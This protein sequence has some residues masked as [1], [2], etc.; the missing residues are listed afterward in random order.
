M[1]ELDS[2]FLFR[3]LYEADLKVEY[4][5]EYIVRMRMGD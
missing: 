3:Y 4:M 2:D 5:K 1:G